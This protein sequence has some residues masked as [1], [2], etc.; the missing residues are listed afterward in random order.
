MT[1]TVHIGE[2][3]LHGTAVT[4][5]TVLTKAVRSA[6]ARHVA[7]SRDQPTPNGTFDP[8]ALSRQIGT[9]IARSVQR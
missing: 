4:D 6:V 2:V 5:R 7:P 8:A 3:V 1:V 9:A